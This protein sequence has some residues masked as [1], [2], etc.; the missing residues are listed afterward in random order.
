MDRKEID[1][2]IINFLDQEGY[3]DYNSA[4]DP[5]P[6]IPDDE[7]SEDWSDTLDDKDP[8]DWET[9]YEPE[10]WGIEYSD[11]PEDDSEA[12]YEQEGYEEMAMEESDNP[13]YKW[14][15]A[16]G[17]AHNET[18]QADTTRGSMG[19]QE[20]IVAWLSR[21]TLARHHARGEGFFV[22]RGARVRLRDGT[23]TEILNWLFEE[24]IVDGA[25][26]SGHSVVHTKPGGPYDEKLSF[27]KV[28]KIVDVPFSKL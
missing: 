4:T 2:D 22:S 19:R 6:D 13:Y 8:D 7:D 18:A 11:L 26:I 1:R 17:G 10:S 16:H 21:S 25:Y 9:H 20:E 24:G 23:E 5:S 28:D 12:G 15:K 3:G 27:F 14:E